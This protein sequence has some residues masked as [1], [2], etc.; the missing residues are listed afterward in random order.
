MFIVVAPTQIML[1]ASFLVPVAGLFSLTVKWRQGIHE[2]RGGGG[3]ASNAAS[4]YRPWLWVQQSLHHA[5]AA[6]YT[7]GSIGGTA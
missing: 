6:L 1:S 2:P 7:R 3:L 4:M 5:T